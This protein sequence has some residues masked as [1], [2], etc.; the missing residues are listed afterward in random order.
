MYTRSVMLRDLERTPVISQDG[1]VLSKKV[2][3]DIK[4]LAAKLKA[5]G[6]TIDKRW[7]RKAQAIFRKELDPPRLRALAAINPGSWWGLLAEG[8][9][10]DFLEQ[11]E[12]HG[13]RLA[14]LDVSPQKVLDSVQESEQ[15]LLV[16]LKDL[17]PSDDHEYYSAL[18]HLYFLVKLKLNDAYYQVR[19]LEATS[20]FEVFQDQL[21]S[22]SVQD[23]LHRVLETLMRTFRAQGG[24]I[25]LKEAESNRLA[26]KAWKGID[27]PLAK[28]FESSVGRGLAG[29]I[30]SRGKPI[31]VV[32]VE[33]ETLTKDPQIR[34]TFKSLWGVPLMVRGKVTGVLE[35]AFSQEYHCLP[36]EM[37]LFEAIAE[38]CA[39]AIDKAQL[40]EE[41][42]ER[43]EQIRALGEHMMRVEEEERRRI[44]RELH[45]EVGQSL[46]V[47][48]LY[49]EMVQNSL[50]PE[51]KALYDKLD[52]ARR[53]AE[54]TIGEMRR[55]ISALSPNVLEE[56]GLG[57]SIRQTVKNVGR[58]FAGRVRVRM[59]NVDG[60]PKGTEI[61]M[62]RLVQECISNAVKH[63][64]A[65]NVNLQL[66][67]RNGCVTLK[68]QDDGKGFDLKEA[69][70]KRESFGLTGMRERVTLLGGQIDVQSSPGKGTKVVI[71]IPV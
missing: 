44:S 60:L 6:T 12:Y 64:H 48:R 30:A 40:T 41:L 4:R 66:G 27:E 56:L 36:R 23:L 67:R 68:M 25:L 31:V 71:E 37:K 3:R 59:A 28:R 69:G 24:L 51:Q 33:S 47:V 43:E 58:T 20:F 46:L 8:R 2:Q 9:I 29:R 32:D 35:L 26:A 15:A 22:L 42:H 16:E 21:E 39:L 11:V 45:D 49:L 50:P 38:R 34:K 10:S 55:L 13:R 19:D 53:V 52:E 18:D 14:K 63:S 7:R 70:R 65:Q 5:R 57:A 17:V 61:M 54:G 62:Y 1:V